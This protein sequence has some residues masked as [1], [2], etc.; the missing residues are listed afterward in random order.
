MAPHGVPENTETRW[1]ISDEGNPL[2]PLR[3]PIP[4]KNG[5]PVEV[6]ELQRVNVKTLKQ[7]DRIPGKVAS[8]AFLLERSAGLPSS[9]IDE[10]DGADF[11]LALEALADFFGIGVEDD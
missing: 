11:N 7:L 2:I 10:I 3:D 4:R 6:L 8:S 1:E 9:V 5:D